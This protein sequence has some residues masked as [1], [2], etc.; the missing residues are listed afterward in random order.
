MISSLENPLHLRV[1]FLCREVCA[2]PARRQGERRNT[3]PAAAAVLRGRLLGL[4]ATSAA[5]LKFLHSLPQSRP[6]TSNRKAAL[7]SYVC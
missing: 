5:D 3:L 7:E 6:G 4:G 1:E 2:T